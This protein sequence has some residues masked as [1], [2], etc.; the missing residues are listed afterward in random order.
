MEHDEKYQQGDEGGMTKPFQWVGHSGA[1]LLG[2]TIDAKIGPPS[3]Q[4]IV[5]ILFFSLCVWCVA[6]NGHG[7]G[8]ILHRFTQSSSEFTRAK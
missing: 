1:A 4:S 6:F 8:S 5:I 7:R 2:S 3:L